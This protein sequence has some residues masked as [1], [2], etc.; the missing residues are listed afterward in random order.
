VQEQYV[1]LHNA[2]LEGID[3]GKTDIPANMLKAHID[4]LAIEDSSA[5]ETGFEQEFRVSTTWLY[6]DMDSSS[7]LAAG[8][9]N[10]CGKV[11]YCLSK[12]QQA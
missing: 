8:K 4:A 2:I 11:Y 6:L 9:Q 1:F 10:W 7:H 3:S 5:G 12:D